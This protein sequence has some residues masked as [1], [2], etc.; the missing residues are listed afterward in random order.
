MLTREHVMSTNAKKQN[1]K[2]TL[3]KMQYAESRDW[4][5]NIASNITLIRKIA[6]DGLILKY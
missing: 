4:Q 5:L 2:K 3:G 6:G 1:K